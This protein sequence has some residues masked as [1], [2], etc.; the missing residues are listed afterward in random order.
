MP[1]SRRTV[2]LGATVATVGA[3]F[4]ATPALAAPQGAVRPLAGGVP[5]RPASPTTH[6]ALTWT[7]PPEL[8]LRVR[9]A[10]GWRS[11]P[12]RA[13]CAAGLDGAPQ[14]NAALVPAPGAVE[15]LVDAGPGTAGTVR[16][17]DATGAPAAAPLVRP[18][19]FDVVTRAGWGADESLR[20]T[21][22]G[23][24]RLP[25]SYYPV[26]AL[27]VHHTV[28]E[29][30]ADP[31]VIIR[32]IYEDHTLSRG[33]GDIGYQVLIDEA[34]LVYEGRWSGTDGEPVFGSSG[35]PDAV[36]A[37]HVGGFNAA[38]V[39]V[40]LLGDF[41]NREPT[42]AALGSL[43]TVLASLARDCGLDPT[44]ST[45]YVNPVDGGTRTVRTVS[46]HQDWNATEC[47]GDQLYPLLPEIR[48]QVAA[49]M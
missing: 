32:G 37:A 36:S 43:V 23:A 12:V 45:D 29:G 33:F 42:G 13:G 22:D 27:T 35:P 14:V 20:F 8:G 11:L 15:Y 17:I 10:A 1:V 48:E 25:P 3:A 41:T 7:G 6:L 5:V 16:E 26:Q 24:E 30:G 34:G 28:V 46:G 38:N 44:G 2:L 49:E 31:A 9:D 18:A 19:A 47:P 4:G 40:S 21:E 39:G